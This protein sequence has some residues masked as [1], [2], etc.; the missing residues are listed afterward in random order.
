MSN[1]NAER[2]LTDLIFV[3]FNS[4]VAA[5]DRFTGEIAWEWKSP[6]GSGYVSIFLDGDRLIAAVN[7]YVYCLD[8]LFGQVV[9][10][11]PMKGFGFGV[12]SVASVNGA[13]DADSVAEAARAAAAA[14]AATAANPAVM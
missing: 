7:G 8:P 4:R 12:T 9:W 10:H 11:N 3:G 13:S 5:L 2:P 6:Q 14:A 1:G